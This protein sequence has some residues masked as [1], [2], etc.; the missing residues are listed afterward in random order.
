MFLHI[1]THKI[2]CIEDIQAKV[3][4]IFNTSIKEERVREISEFKTSLV[5]EQVSGQPGLHSET[6][7]YLPIPKV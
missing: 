3:M 4:N 5:S 2:K 6:S 1:Y 7:F